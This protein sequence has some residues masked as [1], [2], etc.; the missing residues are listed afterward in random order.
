M[1]P[2]SSSKD[3]AN[4]I[5]H[6]PLKTNNLRPNAAGALGDDTEWWR[7]DGMIAASG[8]GTGTGFREEEEWHRLLAGGA[9][10]GE[11]VEG[12]SRE[13]DNGSA[14]HSYGGVDPAAASS[15]S[16]P[17]SRLGSGLGSESPPQWEGASTAATTPK[18]SSLPSD[19][20]AIEEIDQ[21]EVFDLVRS[22]SDPEHPL[23][24]EQLAVVNPNHITITK[25]NGFPHILLEFT[26]TI[27]HCSM[28]TLIGLSLR[29]RL[30]R[31]LPTHYKLDIRVRPGSHQSERSVNK[32][33][34]DKERVA[35]ALE[36]QHLLEVVMQALSTAYKR[37]RTAGS[38]DGA[39]GD[40]EADIMADLGLAKDG[41]MEQV[42]MLARQLGVTV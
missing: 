10:A 16:G 18:I 27:P 29:V 6:S 17:G 11:A 41:A 1:D 24:L 23:T 9:A 42:E 5:I 30:M 20:R 4:P 8:A 36:N 32:Q 25:A 31:S 40:A 19:E 26:P 28:S 38:G 7:D 34:N 37:G 3:N 14:P 13:Q 22:V 12:P 2:S 21:Q 33:L 15:G 39:L 35:A